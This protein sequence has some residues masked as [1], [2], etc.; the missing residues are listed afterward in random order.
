M[1]RPDPQ[2]RVHISDTAFRADLLVTSFPSSDDNIKILID[3]TGTHPTTSRM[4]FP[5]YN[6]AGAAAE[7]AHRRKLE[8]YQKHFSFPP[9][10]L[11]IFAFETNGALSVAS[12]NL[13]RF[14]AQHRCST[15]GSN[16]PRTLQSYY[17][18]ISHAI[19]TGRANQINTVRSQLA[20]R[21]SQL[22]QTPLPIRATYR[23]V[24]AHRV[25]GAVP[26]S[27]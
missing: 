24:L 9:T 11:N 5:H 6:K 13:L 19:Q 21:Q 3:V 17:Q 23:Q 16:Y 20:L 27:Q 7:L 12:E 26:P 15:Q 1:H 14:A 2:H 18:R 4:S 25:Q 8:A 22:L 10:E